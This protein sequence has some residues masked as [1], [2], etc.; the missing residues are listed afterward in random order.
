[1][2]SGQHG[3]AIIVRRLSVDFVGR[4]GRRLQELERNVHQIAVRESTDISIGNGVFP[5]T[6]RNSQLVWRSDLA[7]AGWYQYDAVGGVWNAV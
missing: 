7:P 1:M 5:A 3:D 6:P 4:S 2:F